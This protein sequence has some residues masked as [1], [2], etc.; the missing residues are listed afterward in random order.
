MVPLV[1]THQLK[2]WGVAIKRTVM[3]LKGIRTRVFTGQQQKPVIGG[4]EEKNLV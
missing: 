4:K 3:F 1:Y 2:R